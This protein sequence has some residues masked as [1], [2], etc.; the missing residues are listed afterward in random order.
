MPLD[1]GLP[2][3]RGAARYRSQT[4]QPSASVA[5]TRNGVDERPPDRAAGTPTAAATTSTR[6]SERAASSRARRARRRGGHCTHR[7]APGRGPPAR[8]LGAASWG[9]AR[10]QH[11]HADGAEHAATG[12]DPHHAAIAG[13]ERYAHDLFAV[14]AELELEDLLI[15]LAL[16][17]SALDL[18]AAL[19]R[20]AALARTRQPVPT[21]AHALELAHE[22]TLASLRGMCSRRPRLHRSAR[23]RA[24][25]ASSMTRAPPSPPALVL[26]ALA[27]APAS[28]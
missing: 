1:G 13:V 18:E 27:A 7:P 4:I 11:E 19:R 3:E 25:D 12:N 26:S 22:H 14:L 28:A 24:A 6:D 9:A 15:G 2:D 8:A 10:D 16:R 21:A 5:M 17:R 20:V 23:A